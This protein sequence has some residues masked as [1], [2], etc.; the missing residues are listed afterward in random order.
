MGKKLKRLWKM[1]F[2]SAKHWL[3]DD[4]QRM[5]AALAYFGV[6]ALPAILVV[7]VYVVGLFYNSPDS[8]AKMTQEINS[9][10]GQKSNQ[11]IQ[12]LMSNAQIQ[13]K[14]PMATAIAVV[15]LII[16]VTGVFAELQSDLNSIW[17]VEQKPDIGWGRMILNRGLLLLMMIGIGILLVVSL[18]ASAALTSIQKGGALP[19]GAQLWHGLE[20]IVSCGV[21]T[22][23]FA[24]VFKFLPNTRAHWRDIWIGSF[25]TAILFTIGKLLL[26]IY[27]GSGSI[28]SA[29]G[30]AGSIVITLV[31]VYYSAQIFLYGA[32]FTQIYASEHGRSI[33]PSKEA[34]WKAEG[35]GAAEDREE[36]HT[37]GKPKKT[38]FE[39]KQTPV[40][41]KTAG[42][43][44]D[45]EEEPDKPRETVHKLGDRIRHWRSMRHAKS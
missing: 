29:Y 21:I 10:M 30:V 37:G 4:A 23:L 17:G 32:E 2:A 6:L 11:F 5:G 36:A 41:A 12:G 13:G 34:M 3:A 7:L 16:S 38:D 25:A 18:L 22:V 9:L 20:F 24:M 1:I 40:T 45:R 28:S 42:T 14:G 33:Q 26:G 8:H 43:G 15:V 44:N 35:E 39:P 27:L 19:G 31:W